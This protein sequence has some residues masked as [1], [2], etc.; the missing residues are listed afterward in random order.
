MGGLGTFWH[1]NMSGVTS[2][3][4]LLLTSP[5]AFASRSMHS[6]CPAHAARCMAVRPSESLSS[7]SGAL[8]SG[9]DRRRSSSARSP[10]RAAPWRL[11]AAICESER[12]GGAL[13]VLSLC[14]LLPIRIFHR[15]STDMNLGLFKLTY[16]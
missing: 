15:K 12:A 5:P 7:G 8:P 4:A 16:G 1:A 14:P 6:G 2:S 13:S 9:S 3:T 11:F 10:E